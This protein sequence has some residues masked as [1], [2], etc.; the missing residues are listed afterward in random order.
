MKPIHSILIG[1]P[2]ALLLAGCAGTDFVRAQDNTLK[3][4]STTY[5]S[6]RA[7]MGSSGKEGVV[8]MNDRQFKKLN[9]VYASVGGEALYSGVTP[10]R[11][12]TFYFDDQ[13]LVG[14]DFVSSFK[15]DNTDFDSAKVSEIKEGISTRA[16]VISLL[17]V[18]AGRYVYPMVKDRDGEALLYLYSH[19][20]GS[21]FSMKFYVKRLSVEFDSQGTVNKVEFTESS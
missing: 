12:Q 17:G 13:I 1:L 10:A 15:S 18:P 9:Y 8:T 21:A 20:T 3:L 14:Y 5:Q 7:R 11:G 19:A 2:V 4:G 16:D 6:I